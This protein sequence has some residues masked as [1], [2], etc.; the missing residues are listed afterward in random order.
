MAGRVQPVSVWR[1]I[2][3]RGM[4][5]FAD[6]EPLLPSVV[7][8]RTGI[9]RVFHSFLSRSAPGGNVCGMRVWRRFFSRSGKRQFVRSA[10]PSREVW[11]GRTDNSKEFLRSQMLTKRIIACL[12]VDAGRVVKGTQ[13][14]ALRDAGDP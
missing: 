10:I 8:N 14:L 11:T 3:P 1:E 7:R 9:V 12:D 6:P 13:F 5:Q 4:E 2:S